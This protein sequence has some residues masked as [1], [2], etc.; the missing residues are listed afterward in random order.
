MEEG[1]HFLLVYCNY[2]VGW[3]LEREMLARDHIDREVM[4]YVRLT[5]EMGP[6]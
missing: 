1:L 3:G 2:Y 4:I 5:M 6:M